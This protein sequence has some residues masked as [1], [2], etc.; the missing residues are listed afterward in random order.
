MKKHLL[1]AALACMGMSAYAETYYCGKNVATPDEL[2]S[3]KYFLY[4]YTKGA[5]GFLHQAGSY[6]AAQDLTEI[7]ANGI[8]N[9][10]SYIYEIAVS[11]VN[12]VKTF[13]IKA[14]NELYFG[15]HGAGAEGKG[16]ITIDYMADA[17]SEEI[18]QY[19]FA[20]TEMGQPTDFDGKLYS[21]QLNNGHFEGN[22][23]KTSYLTTNGDSGSAHLS[24]WETNDAVF[25]NTDNHFN[26]IAFF[27][28]SETPIGVSLASDFHIPTESGWYAIQTRTTPTTRKGMWWINADEEFQQNANNCYALRLDDKTFFEDQA[29]PARGIVYVEIDGDN[30]Y[31]RSIN[32]HYSTSKGVCKVSDNEPNFSINGMTRSVQF[33]AGTDG[34]NKTCNIGNYWMEWVAA[35]NNGQPGDENPN[36]YVFN[37]AGGSATG[38]SYGFYAANPELNYDIWTVTIENETYQSTIKNNLRVTL[39][40]P[41][42]AGLASVYHNGNFFLP[43]GS[44]IT[45]SNLS[46][47]SNDAH[48]DMVATFTIDNTAHTIVASMGHPSS[49][50]RPLLE[51]YKEEQKAS[52]TAKLAATP[53]YDAETAA[54]KITTIYNNITI[55]DSDLNEEGLN[56]AKDKVDVAGINAVREIIDGKKVYFASHAGTS[57]GS[58]NGNIIGVESGTARHA[59][60]STP[61]D[62]RAA[63]EINFTDD[64]HLTLHN[65]VFDNYMH[66]LGVDSQENAT[67]YK[68][69]FCVDTSASHIG[70]FTFKDESHDS[71][72]YLN[73]GVNNTIGYWYASNGNGGSF[74]SIS[75][76]TPELEQTWFDTATAEPSGYTMGE[77]PGLY[78]KS[79]KYD[80]FIELQDQLKA[81]GVENFDYAQVA[82][83]L[84]AEGRTP[85]LFDLK[86]LAG[87]ALIQMAYTPTGN[88]FIIT[89]WNNHWEGNNKIMDQNFDGTAGSLALGQPAGT[90]VFDSGKLYSLTSGLA[91]V[92]NGNKPEM[93]TGDDFT[94]N[95]T[96]AI[97]VDFCDVAKTELVTTEDGVARHS[98]AIKIA[99]TD[100]TFG[101]SS[102]GGYKVGGLGTN[103]GTPAGNWAYTVQY[104][105]NLT[106]NVKE[107]D[108]KLWRTPV[109]VNFDGNTDSGAYVVSVNGT[110]IT[111]DPVEG[112]DTYG[113]GTIFIL[114]RT[115]NLNVEN[116][117][118]VDAPAAGLGHHAKQTHTMTAGKVY[119]SIH[120]DAVAPETPEAEQNGY[121]MYFD[122]PAANTVKMDVVIPTEDTQKVLEAH[123]ALIEATN[124]TE[125]PLQHGTTMDLA[126]GGSSDTT[127]LTEIT[128]EGRNT[129]SVYDLQGRKLAAPAKGI[130]II[131]GQKV[132]V[133]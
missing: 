37:G 116:G 85:D 106:V 133:K 57:N 68:F 58:T 84:N 16:N 78:V 88:G 69:E 13:T 50:L 28:A 95:I 126:L 25:P 100:L 79:D 18:A 1:L 71:Y 63:W 77:E 123:E 42:N 32:G 66:G 81:A 51:A 128:A 12:G 75:L 31:I 115:V 97:T 27:K 61:I 122:A 98:Y 39:N 65:L 35:K 125:D 109:A 62:I 96:D 76:V 24:Y 64:T 59:T 34:N 129:N 54:A 121:T 117:V 70:A 43:K 26:G 8:V 23:E 21:L 45:K 113:A 29:T 101:A 102:G 94:A 17:N 19:I 67:E 93:F 99:G 86:T 90:F 20:D 10:A 40:H 80:Q 111:T 114:T 14:N 110:R 52:M 2:T 120:T 36:G 132:L 108:Y 72:N 56:A 38:Y 55:A 47:I 92:N 127:Q 107:G 48:A 46:M 131:N 6:A 30:H 33:S 49:Q 3:G 11:E 91:V 83:V 4:S 89:E 104:V 124:S 112:S 73:Q 103:S 5:G 105:K 7:S 60:P 130:N 82:S 41:Q 87:P 53:W 9:D 15:I 118:A 74:W 44:T 22:T 119:L